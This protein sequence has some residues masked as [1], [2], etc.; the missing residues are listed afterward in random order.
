MSDEFEPPKPFDFNLPWSGAAA[1]SH[2]S[3]LKS[4]I[5]QE[6]QRLENAKVELKLRLKQRRSLERSASKFFWKHLRSWRKS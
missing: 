6:R 1:A 5:K 3:A 4:G 2:I